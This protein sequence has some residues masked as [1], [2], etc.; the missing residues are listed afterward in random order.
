MV[1]FGLDQYFDFIVTSEEAG[2]DKPDNG[3]FDIALQKINPK[4]GCIWMIGDH[5]EKDIM[6][7]K[8]TIGAITLQK[9]DEVANQKEKEIKADLIFN[10][11]AEVRK[12][13]NELK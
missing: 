12:L 1:Y 3:P 5:P 11:Y 4:G 7:S 6:G 10:N 13:I 9:L 2:K 8:E